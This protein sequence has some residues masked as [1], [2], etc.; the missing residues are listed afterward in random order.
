MTRAELIALAAPPCHDCQEPVQ[1]VEGRYHLDEDERWRPGPY[2][3]V[4]VDGH[5]VLVEP[6]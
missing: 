4:C 1:R 6:F 5:R 2:Y 3:M